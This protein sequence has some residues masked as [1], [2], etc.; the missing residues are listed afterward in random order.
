MRF[1]TIVS[2]ESGRFCG[3]KRRAKD[4]WLKRPVFR[5]DTFPHQGEVMVFHMKL[6]AD[7]YLVAHHDLPA[8]CEVKWSDLGQDAPYGRPVVTPSSEARPSAPTPASPLRGS[9]EETP[10]G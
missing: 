3:Y 4:L 1:Y 9:G 2:R 8:D 5:W 7:E 10:F 6:Q